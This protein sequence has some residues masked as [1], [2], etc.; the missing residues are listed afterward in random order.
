MQ[1]GA[2]FLL[3]DEVGPET[4]HEQRVKEWGERDPVFN[5]QLKLYLKSQVIVRK[6]FQKGV[7][8]YK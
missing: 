3:G 1:T 8:S 7:K 6:Y 5:V 2:V 4:Q